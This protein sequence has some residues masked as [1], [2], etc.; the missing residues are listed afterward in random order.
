M[1]IASVA[2]TGDETGQ[3]LTVGLRFAALKDI[4]SLVSGAYLALARGQELGEFTAKD[5]LSAPAQAA[6]AENATQSADAAPAGR[7]RRHVNPL[8]AAEAAPEATAPLPPEAPTSRRRRGVAPAEAA[9]ASA[10]SAQAPAAATPAPTRR[11]R[12]EASSG[13]AA[14]ATAP[15]AAPQS[16]SDLS[17]ADLSKAASTA[18]AS[19]TPK[20]V[21]AY[22]SEFG[23]QAVQM[24]KGDDRRKFVGG[25]KAKL[26]A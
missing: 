4:S 10:A 20:V 12:A 3:V 5:A 1:K 19:L 14:M 22:L 13:A 25:L 9:P 16:P 26:A 8:A 7:R 21:M 6:P 23:V 11:R 17:D 18:A 24:L 2:V 15:A